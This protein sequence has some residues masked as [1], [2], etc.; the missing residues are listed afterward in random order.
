MKATILAI[1]IFLGAGTLPQADISDKVV[2]LLKAGNSKELSSHFAS[3]IDL[4]VEDKD[5]V[6]SRAQAE[7]IIKKFFATHAPTSVTVVHSGTSNMGIKY[8][9][10][11]M[12]TEKGT[13]RVSFHVKEVGGK[14]YIQKLSIEESD[15]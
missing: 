9:I 1:I 2:A 10:C 13:F 7:L 8:S 12:V 11:N 14:G 6:Y 5:D 3:K 15:G 4:A